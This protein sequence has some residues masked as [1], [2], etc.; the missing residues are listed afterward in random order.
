MASSSVEEEREIVAVDRHAPGSDLHRRRISSDAARTRG[1]RDCDVD[2]SGIVD[3]GGEVHRDV[4]VEPVTG[5]TVYGADLRDQRAQVCCAANG[6]VDVG[7]RRPGVVTERERSTAE[8][9]DVRRDPGALEA[10]QKVVESCTE[11]LGWS[12]DRHR[13]RP[14]RTR[15]RER[16]RR[17][18]QRPAAT[19]PLQPP[20]GS[21]RRTDTTHRRSAKRR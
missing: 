12:A 19:P 1:A 11:V 9:V 14:D 2:R 7:D 20:S 4:R 13:L 5:E 10:V 16:I 15:R 18:W 3:Q 8:E 21:R 6:C 17:V